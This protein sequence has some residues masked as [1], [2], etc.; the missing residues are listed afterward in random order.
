VSTAFPS[1]PAAAPS[2]ASQLVDRIV[3]RNRLSS[4]FFAKTLE[5]M[6]PADRAQLEDYLAACAARGLSLER[7]ADAYDLVTKDTLRE[8]IHFRRTGRYRYARYDDVAQA[9]YQN[10]NYMQ[11][12]MLGLA[13]T[14]FFWPN[15]AVIRR[16]FTERLPRERRG[17]YLE[18]GP[19]HGFYFLAAMRL[20]A[21]DWF[22]GI[23]I[24]PTSVE[25]TR[26]LVEAG[27]PRRPYDW[28]IREGDFLAA[29]FTAPFDM[30]VMGEVLEHVEAP[31]DF[32]E[33]ARELMA[34]GGTL[35]ATT[36]INSPALDHIHLFRSA[37]E[38]AALAADAGLRIEDQIVLPYHGT[39]LEESAKKRLPVNIALVLR[40]A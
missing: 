30:L 7:L 1:A 31:L 5:E 32:L 16:Y 22:E 18:V 36:C 27:A 28:S 6:P 20:G 4:P 29:R 24:S 35:F 40:H 17:R 23:D 33:R 19:G 13:L 14:A 11:R 34:D 39:S 8:Q 26:S 10:P 38:I 15:H 37:E 9:V 21:F 3:R 2:L 12:Y 25:M